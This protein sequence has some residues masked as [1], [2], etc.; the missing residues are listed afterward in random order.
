MFNKLGKKK[1]PLA[2]YEFAIDVVDEKVIAGWAKNTKLPNHKP[3]IDV[4]SGDTILWQVKAE[5]ER[6]DLNEQG[7]GHFA[8]HLEPN[9]EVLTADISELDVYIDGFKANDKPYFCEIKKANDLEHFVSG[10]VDNL[11]DGRN[12]PFIDKKENHIICHV[13]MIEE[14]GVSG[15]ARNRK[16]DSERLLIEFKNQDTI[17]ASG[18]A[19]IF[20]K[21]LAEA[22]VGDGHY[23][24]KLLFNLAAFPS[25]KVEGQL[26]V[27]GELY[28]EQLHTFEV[29]KQ[30]LED[31]K[32]TDK[33]GEQIRMFDQ[34]LSQEIERINEQISKAS[35]GSSEPSLNVAVNIA[36]QNIAELNTRMS[37]LERVMTKYLESK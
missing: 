14:D 4:Y 6:D 32:F 33:F 7:V 36:L 1:S 31:A 29:T 5:L 18:K 13:D 25:E 15:W 37:V 26:F 16:N 9:P 23:G 28:S 11:N 34:G 12:E 21:D 10:E 20:R 17:I 3:V 27:N 35:H 22:G 2:H 24:Y 30:A 19:D 8:F